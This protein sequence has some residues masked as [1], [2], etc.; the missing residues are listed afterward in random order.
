MVNDDDHESLRRAMA[1][2]LIRTIDPNRSERRESL[3]KRCRDMLRELEYSGFD[4]KEHSLC[5]ICSAYFHDEN[6]TCTLSALLAELNAE[7]LGE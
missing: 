5:P 1:S 4:W 3:L 2:E 6:S 7:A